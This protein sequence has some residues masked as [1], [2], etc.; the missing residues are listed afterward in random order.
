M[1]ISGSMRLNEAIST[2]TRN[3]GEGANERETKK[4]ITEN[5]FVFDDNNEWNIKRE[6]F[7]LIINRV[8]INL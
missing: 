5:E 8:K 4:K 6:G 7:V 3:T 1:Q 2:F